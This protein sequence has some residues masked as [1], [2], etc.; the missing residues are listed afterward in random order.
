MY[1]VGGYTA[2]TTGGGSGTSRP[3]S[4]SW[5]PC[6]AND[7]GVPPDCFPE[8]MSNTIRY[9]PA[10]SLPTATFTVTDCPGATVDG[11]AVNTWLPETSV[12]SVPFPPYA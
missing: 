2:L 10:G 1:P 6:E 8:Y 12:P 3:I 7:C 4:K 5:I 11:S 9:G